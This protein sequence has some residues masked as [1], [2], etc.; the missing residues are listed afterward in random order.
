[1]YL[2]HFGLRRPPFET[3][4]NPASYVDLP[5]HRTARNCVLFGLRS[6][7]A[8]VKVVGE[9]GTGKTALC[10]SLLETLRDEFVTIHLPD[11]ARSRIDLLRAIAAALSVSSDPMT[12]DYDLLE[13]IQTELRGFERRGTRCLILVDEAQTLP[14]DSLETLRLLTNFEGDRGRLVQVALFAQPELDD[15]LADFGLRQLQQRIAFSAR[16]TPLDRSACREY[17]ECRLAKA[18]ARSTALFTPAALERIHRGS[19]GLPRLVNVLCHKSLIAAFAE[20]DH[21]VARR[22]VARAIADT[23]GITRWRTRPLLGRARGAKPRS[24]TRPHVGFDW[25]TSSD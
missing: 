13:A 22:H 7:E 25:Q 2:K 15:R 14:F 23:E 5:E 17:V 1:M 4:S 12:R 9:V 8:L 3:V 6:G 19:S 21:Q 11:P 16:L 18:R 10:R 20:K 24:A